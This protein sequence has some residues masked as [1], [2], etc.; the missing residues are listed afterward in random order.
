MATKGAKYTHKSK[1]KST[2]QVPV[3]AD[4]STKKPT[5]YLFSEW[6]RKWSDY[7][8]IMSKS[9]CST[10]EKK[11]H[12]SNPGFCIERKSLQKVFEGLGIDLKSCGIY[13]I[14]VKKPGGGRLSEDAVKYVGMTC[15][16]EC[17]FIDRFMEYCT[18]G[19]HLNSEINSCLVDGYDVYVRYKPSYNTSTE[20]STTQQAKEEEARVLSC[21][22]YPWNIQLNS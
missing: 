1:S 4:R 5:G 22:N 6:S 9:Q 10:C 20:K 15:R 19:S 8:L 16:E 7:V 12:D 13:E 14:M 11:R 2:K 17:S 18:T 3:K 21:F